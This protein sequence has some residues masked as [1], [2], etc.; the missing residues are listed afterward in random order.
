MRIKNVLFLVIFLAFIA[1]SIFSVVSLRQSAGWPSCRLFVQK[2]AEQNKIRF[3]YV[4]DQGSITFAADKHYATIIKTYENGHV[5]YEEY[6]DAAGKPA[7]QPLGQYALARHY[8]SQGFADEITYLG[9]DGKPITTTSGYTKIIRTYN[10][11][12][13]AD[14]DTYSDAKGHQVKH[15]RGYYGYHREYD[16]NDRVR[17]ITY[18]DFEHKPVNNIY[19]FAKIT[20][21]YNEEGKIK[22]QYYFDVK[23][24]P[25]S[26]FSGFYG[27]YREYDKYGNVILITYLDA[28]GRP[29]NTGKGYATI[30]RTYADDGTLASIR[31]FDAGGNPATAGRNQY[32]ITY[33]DG[34]AVYLDKNGDQLFRLDNYL[35]THP[36]YVLIF[37]IVLTLLAMLSKGKYRMVF[38]FLY[39]FLIG[40]L[41]L[42]YR[43]ARDPRS[44]LELFWSYKL[45]FSHPVIRQEIL[46]NIWLFVPLGAAL[47]YPL[48]PR[49]SWLCIVP[50]LLS[51]TIETVQY[52]GGIGLCE[53]DDVISNGVG[54]LLGYG[55]AGFLNPES[56]FYPY[57]KT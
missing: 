33:I 30:K 40:M 32:G 37:G 17:A 5:V 36:E 34:Q 55:L 50:V 53:A 15:L 2:T 51:L 11:K 18:L 52:F 29:M 48:F 56:F 6:F 4:N 47:H 22:N 25:V 14:T 39:I 42:F 28:S 27:F 38:L 24:L 23:G 13:L 57:E 7:R 35:N 20:R 8:N 46:N 41:T 26:V 3:D 16:N 45:F 44:Q 49:K 9:A 21:T 19:G 1:L 31:Y 12:N 54:G 10:Q 43:E